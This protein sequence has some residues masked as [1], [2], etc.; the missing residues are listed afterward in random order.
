MSNKSSN[1]G[2]IGTFYLPYSGTFR[3]PGASRGKPKLKNSF[4]PDPHIP[5]PTRKCHAQLCAP[6]FLILGA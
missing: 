2:S 5:I 4:Y 6:D 3:G 1:N